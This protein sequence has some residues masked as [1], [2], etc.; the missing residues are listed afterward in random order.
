MGG[1][2]IGIW[3]FT[4]AYI[5]K[6]QPAKDFSKAPMAKRQRGSRHIPRWR[7]KAQNQP[8]RDFSVAEP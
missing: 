6:D 8:R 1:W 4:L 2:P 3:R 7:Q 5:G